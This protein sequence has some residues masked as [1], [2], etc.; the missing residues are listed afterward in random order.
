MNPLFDFM[1]DH[2]K[3]G[4]VQKQVYEVVGNDWLDLL[5]AD[6][7]IDFEYSTAHLFRYE[8]V[9]HVFSVYS[10]RN[11]TGQEFGCIMTAGSISLPFAKRYSTL[12]AVRKGPG[13][14]EV[15]HFCLEEL[16]EYI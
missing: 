4:R 12:A 3:I 5:C 7:R 15:Y 6:L 1:Y 16:W 2:L 14:G 13:E 10:L 11:L 9:N 8:G